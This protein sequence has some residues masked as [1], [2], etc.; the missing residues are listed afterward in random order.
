M[1]SLLLN[2]HVLKT[3]F[4][5][6]FNLLRCF[7]KNCNCRCS[8]RIE[9][10]NILT[11]C[12]NFEYGPSELNLY[13][14]IAEEARFLWTRARKYF[15]LKPESEP[16]RGI[17]LVHTEGENLR[18]LCRK[19]LEFDRHSTSFSEGIVRSEKSISCDIF[20]MN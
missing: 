17:L 4:T 3:L 10:S 1:T 19:H 18:L 5:L 2:K 6:F 8:E 15:R 16:T 14:Y 9:R 20:S 7:L 11:S 12:L 13:D